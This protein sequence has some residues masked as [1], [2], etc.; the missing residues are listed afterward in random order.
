MFA[1]HGLQLEIKII[2]FVTRFCRLDKGQKTHLLDRYYALRIPVKQSSVTFLC[3]RCVEILYFC[4]CFSGQKLKSIGEKVTSAFTQ[5][6][7]MRYMDL[8]AMG[9]NCHHINKYSNYVNRTCHSSHHSNSTTYRTARRK[10]FVGKLMCEKLAEKACAV[11]KDLCKGETVARIVRV[12]NH[13]ME[14]VIVV[15]CINT[16]DLFI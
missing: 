6:R 9:M 7:A 4:I 12:T 5:D 11:T 10:R 13:F 1:N 14:K 8:L 15:S 16:L 2:C 3:Q